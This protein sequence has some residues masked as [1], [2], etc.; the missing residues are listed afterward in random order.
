MFFIF[1]KMNPIWLH[2]D[3]IDSYSQ[4]M[5]GTL[6]P[7]KDMCE[8][9]L[10]VQIFCLAVCHIFQKTRKGQIAQ[11]NRLPNWTRPFPWSESW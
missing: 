1:T 2:F 8:K 6:L 11:F 4:F 5:F 9:Q 7:L 10:Q 3:F